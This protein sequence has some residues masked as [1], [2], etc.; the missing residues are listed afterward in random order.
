VLE[1]IMT[2]AG[3]AFPS[4]T[5]DEILDQLASML[6]CDGVTATERDGRLHIVLRRR[7]AMNAD[8]QRRLQEWLTAYEGAHRDTNVSEQHLF[9]VD[10]PDAHV[11][12]LSPLESALEKLET[13]FT[14]EEREALRI[15]EL[16]KAI[17]E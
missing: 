2:E 12:R 4:R 1:A 7:E 13:Y 6:P 10:I 11:R 8:E 15:Y 3:A 9:E 17:V 16:D 14:P 5:K